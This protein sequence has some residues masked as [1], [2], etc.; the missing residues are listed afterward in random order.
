MLTRAQMK[1]ARKLMASQGGKAGGPA[2]AKSLTAARR[3]EIA[4]KAAKAMH[5][6]QREKK[7]LLDKTSN[8]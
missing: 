2:R 6:N 8:D 1:E 5:R 4:S 7:A 3:K